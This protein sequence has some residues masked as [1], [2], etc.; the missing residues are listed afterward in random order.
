[1]I[2]TLLQ[3]RSDEG[4]IARDEQVLLKK[5]NETN[6]RLVLPSPMSRPVTDAVVA[7]REK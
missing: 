1:M 5:V 6:F 7:M 4:H 2:Y 3:A